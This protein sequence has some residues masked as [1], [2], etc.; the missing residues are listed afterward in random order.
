MSCPEDT[1]VKFNQ[2]RTLL[3]WIWQWV[4]HKKVSPAFELSYMKTK[5]DQFLIP[6][7]VVS[8]FLRNPLVSPLAMPL[9]GP[10]WHRG[11]ILPF[12]SLWKA[13]VHTFWSLKNVFSSVFS[14]SPTF[15]GRI[16]LFLPLCV[17]ILIS[18]SRDTNSLSLHYTFPSSGFPCNLEVSFFHWK[19]NAAL[20]KS[21]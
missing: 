6:F 5:R 4:F 7:Y 8:G 11:Q 14:K 17:F 12:W 2:S 18:F 10:R 16:V 19:E 9:A 15:G 1:F 21:G 13:Q 3:P 20:G